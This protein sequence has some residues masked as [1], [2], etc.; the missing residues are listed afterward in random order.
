[1]AKLDISPKRLQINKASAVLV[2]SVGVASFLLI[3]MLVSARALLDQRSYQNRVIEKKEKAKTQLEANIKAVDQL[4][5]SYKLFANASTNVLGGSPTGPGE[6]DG[7]NARIVLDALPSKYDAVALATSLEKLLTTGG[8]TIK[9]LVVVD[10]EEGKA[11]AAP[12]TA[13][14]NAN[15]TSAIEMPFEVGISGNYDSVTRLLATFENSIRPIK[16]NKLTLSGKNTDMSLS[17]SSVTYYL[18]AKELKITTQE[19]K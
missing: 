9:A 11:P 10:Q 3:F 1:M 7:D 16:V 4:K 14:A 2:G 8:Y 12:T 18:P 15:K 5:E 17:L 13:T 6:K 19:V